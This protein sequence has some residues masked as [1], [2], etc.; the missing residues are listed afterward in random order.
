MRL[1]ILENG[2]S[3]VQKAAF[4]VMRAILRGP[5][6]GPILVLSYRRKLFGKYMAPCFHE[7][8]R[9]AKEWRVAEVEL[10]AAF[11]S[12]LNQCRY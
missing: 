4:S 8:L 10:F 5:V 2:H 7:A 3:P 11:V 1:E 6:P 9:G 12:R